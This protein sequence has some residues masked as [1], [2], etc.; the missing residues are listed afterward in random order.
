M[1][2]RT[3]IARTATPEAHML[4]AGELARGANSLAYYAMFDAASAAL[5][6]ID[7][8]LGNAKTHRTMISRFSKHIA[9]SVDSIGSLHK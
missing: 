4:L 8:P 3:N 6:A 5:C 7:A 9:R 2:V 1:R